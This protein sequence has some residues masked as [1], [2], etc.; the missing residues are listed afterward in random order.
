M[1]LRKVEKIEIKKAILHILNNQN[2]FIKESDYTLE[3]DD[4]V[5]KFLKEHILKSLHDDKTRAAQFINE[6]NPVKKNCNNIFN[7]LC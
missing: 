6:S 5:K 1:D 3:I 2:E 4:K 7:K